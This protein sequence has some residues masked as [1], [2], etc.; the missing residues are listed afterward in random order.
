M[1]TKICYMKYYFEIPHEI[2]TKANIHILTND[3][4]EL[5][6]LD[7]VIKSIS[8]NFDPLLLNIRYVESLQIIPDSL[9]LSFSFYDKPI[10]FKNYENIIRAWKYIGETPLMALKRVATDHKIPHY[11]KSCYTGRL[12]P[13][14]QGKI[15]M[16]Y[17]KNSL[18]HK[19]HYNFHD[20]TY[21]FQAVLGFSTT[22]YDPLGFIR[23]TKVVSQQDA[24]RYFHAMLAK[25]GKFIQVLPPCSAYIY[26][27]KPLWSYHINNNLPEMMPKK[28]R[29]IINIRSLHELPVEIQLTDYLEECIDDINDVKEN[30]DAVFK[31]SDIIKQWKDQS[32]IMPCVW[33]LQFEIRVSAGTYIR[34]LVHDTGMDLGIPA[35]AFRITRIGSEASLN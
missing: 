14:A 13:M 33:R 28:E 22:S 17:G 25:K 18:Q 26:K 7:I 20:K 1:T 30:N 34:S 19:D 11:V 2:L 8:V 9:K 27:G 3:F 35:H 23:D 6:N 24:T 10:V 16:L 15:V 21:R 32:E 12:D 31:C 5:S 4:K 29:E